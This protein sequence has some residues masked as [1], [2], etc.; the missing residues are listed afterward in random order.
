MSPLV[1]ICITLLIF[2]FSSAII[3]AQ[4]PSGSDPLYPL[5]KNV[6]V[7]TIFDNSFGERNVSYFTT[8]E[9]LA[10]IDGDVIYGTEAQ[11]L[12]S[13]FRSFAVKQPWPGATVVYKYDTAGTAARVAAIVNTAI[14]RWQLVSPYLTFQQ[15]SN[16]VT[17]MNGVL[18]ISSNDCGGCNANVGFGALL[19]L[20]MNLQQP[21]T[22]C[23]GSCGPN[24]ATHEL[25]HVLG[26]L[27]EHQ[28]PDRE[29]TVNYHC[30][31]LSPNCTGGATMPAGS[32]CCSGAPPGCCG[33]AHNFDI[34][35][36][37]GKSYEYQY[38]V[39]SVM[40]YVSQAFALPGTFT[41]TPVNTTVT[42]PTAHPSNP[43]V[44]DFERVCKIY[45]AQCPQAQSCLALGC[46]YKEK[47]C[48]DFGSGYCSFHPYADG[49]GGSKAA[50]CVEKNEMCKENGCS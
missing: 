27:H 18:T 31:N 26:L 15:L 30:E 11:L 42:L 50:K 36:G 35:S 46:P 34:I 39:N 9:R 3:A 4:T 45:E 8:V 10:I 25:G 41:L 6:S 33:N 38:D 40:H 48:T 43:D 44:P 49:C 5:D 22:A 21:S 24:E 37:L 32:D 12:S 2:S 19:P 16:N 17:P 29:R 13:E 7:A 28:R 23:N 14:V 47:A 1:T 20:Q